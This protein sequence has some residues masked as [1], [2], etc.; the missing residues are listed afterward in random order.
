MWWG[1]DAGLRGAA[2]GSAIAVGLLGCRTHAES[3]TL[4]GDQGTRIADQVAFDGRGAASRSTLDLDEPPSIEGP[5]FVERWCRDVVPPS[6]GAIASTGAQS[7]AQACD[8]ATRPAPGL[9]SGLWLSPFPGP[10]RCVVSAPERLDSR[11]RAEPV[12]E[13]EVEAGTPIRAPARGTV[14]HSATRAQVQSAA[15]RETALGG[16][17]T[18]RTEHHGRVMNVTL[19]GVNSVVG[20]RQTV[21]RGEIVGYSMMGRVRLVVV[22]FVPVEQRLRSGAP[23]ID[24]FARAGRGE[25]SGPLGGHSEWLWLPASERGFDARPECGPDA[26]WTAGLPGE[27]TAPPTPLPHPR[28][29]PPPGR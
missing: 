15:G 8:D 28:D 20:Y 13:F 21:Q 26:P 23:Y 24:A 19:R 11:S 18:I 10:F 16:A 2:G 14:V 27:D 6:A 22:D 12:Y 9:A 17:V 25:P 1:I 3:E 5:E 7:W 29:A 4:A